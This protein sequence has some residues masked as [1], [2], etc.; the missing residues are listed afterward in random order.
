MGI[1]LPDDPNGRRAWE[2][3]RLVDPATG[4]I[5]ADI[6]RRE[7]AFVQA[8]PKRSLAKSLDW[9]WRGPRNRGGRTRALAIDITD[10]QVILAGG[11][12]GGMWRSTDAGATWNKTTASMEIQSVSCVAQDIRA[13][14]TST[15]YYGTGENYGIVSGTSFSALMPGDGIF[16]STDGGISWQ[17]LPSSIAG[18]HHIFTRN[19]SF[20]QVNSIV[21]DHTDQENDVV[22]A[23]V[24]N[25]IFRSTDGGGSWTPV[26]GLDTTVNN[27]GTYT[28]LRITTDGVFYAAISRNSPVKG[29]YRSTDG[30]NWTAITPPGFPTMDNRTVLAID[31]SNEARVYWFTHTPN[32]GTFSHSLWR[33][34]YLSGDGSGE[35]GEWT[36]LSANLPAGSCTGYF[37]FDFAYINSQSGYDMCIAVHPTESNVVYIGGTNIYRST[38]GF[39]TPS[40]TDWI[41]G[42]ICTP[43]DPKDYVYPGHHPDQHAF[44]F[45][46]GQPDVLYSAHDGG[47]SVTYDA[48]AEPIQWVPL[49]TQYITSQFYTVHIEEGGATSPYIMGGTQDNG[50][51]LALSDDPGEDWAYVHID[52]GAHGAIPVGRAFHLTSSQLGR[53]YK[54]TFDGQG[55]M[56]GFERIDPP[57]GGAYNFIN[58]LVLD[59][60]NNN[61]LYWPAGHRIF[62]NNDLA[63]IPIT[64]NWYNANNTNWEQLT[65]VN[66]PSN[67][68]ITSLDISEARPS[69]L[70]IGTSNR[71]VYRIEG[72][73]TAEPTRTEVTVPDMPT[74]SYV[75]CV[76]PNDNDPDEWIVTYSNYGIL[77]VFRTLD[78]GAN[79]E[80]VSGNLEE[81]LDGSGAGPAVF[82]AR[83][84]DN[85]VPEEK[86]YYV[87]TSTG[88]YS[89]A[90][91]AGMATVWEQEGAGSIGNIPVNMITSRQSDGLIAIGTHGNGIYS[92]FLPVGPASV[93]GPAAASQQP[94]VWPNPAVD[95]ALLTL[96]EGRWRAQ[97]FA[98]DGSLMLDRSIT[99]AGGDAGW[100]WDLR[101]A[102]GARVAPGNYLIHLI[103]PAGNTIFTRLMVL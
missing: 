33:Y 23:A 81:E 38:D 12:T 87:A 57:G 75:S 82:W 95:H 26:L 86:R 85:N 60:S 73:D 17:Q 72:L 94:L 68:R 70:F 8:L 84:H 101:A 4:A 96:P 27:T 79:W 7:L 100:R 59:P 53:L 22:L 54:K 5:P 25:G 36:N 80:A 14:H 44:A 50:A 61:V 58:P 31:P 62:R 46:P 67:Q 91:L 43:E 64:D 89:T 29:F 6:R 39:T 16:K 52:D 93:N 83:I 55:V 20:K 74:G 66:L 102:D 2:M 69:T 90:S 99:S 21:V 34:D 49:N 63:G 78:S 65:I 30:I 35:G 47:V 76:A 24:F 11:V 18:D 1:G 15:W 40:N 77:S 13:G 51:W 3:E 10:T 42:Y 32:A 103:S 97:V 56:T 48:L 98:M 9:T 71:R 19:G 28:D 92:S 37:D 41:G 45:V 88:L